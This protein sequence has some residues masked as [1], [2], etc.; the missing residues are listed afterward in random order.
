MNKA[1]KNI[2]LHSDIFQRLKRLYIIAFT[3]I[4]ASIIVSQILIQNHINSQISDSRVI[5]IAG[6]QR[7]L[8][9]KLTKEILLLNDTDNLQEREQKIQ[10][11]S[12]TFALWVKSHNGLIKGDNDLKLPAEKN[13]TI[14]EM[15]N[16]IDPN[17]NTIK[18][19]ISS[20]LNQLTAYPSTSTKT[21][22]NY[23]QAVLKHEEDF[24]FKMDNIVFKYD[25]ISNKKVKKL[26]LL[27]TILIG[28]SLLI[29]A[30]EILFLF[31]PTSIR[32]RDV[33]KDLV[34]TKQE[35]I[36]KAAELK[37]MYLSREKSLQELQELNYAID[38]AVLF[39]SISSEGNVMYISKK[40]QHFLGLKHMDIKG[41]AE[42]VI[43]IDEGHQVYLNEL[44]YNR[45]TIWHGEV[46][47]TN[48]NKE[49]KWLD[50]SI[51]PMTK[52]SSKQKTLILCN[53]ITEKKQSEV[54]LEK[55]T[56]EQFEK[57]I[58]FRKQQSINIIEA[59]E[60]E[61]KR[62]AKDIHDGIGQMLTALKF[63][64]ESINIK[65]IESSAKKVEGLKAL[66]KQIIKGVRIATFNLTP[67]ELT[68]HGIASALQNLTSQLQVLTGKTILFDNKNNFNDRLDSTIE[69]NLYRIT[70]EAVNNAIKYA[71]SNIVMV[72]MNHSE[73]LL[74]ITIDDDGI[75]FEIDTIKKDEKKG[76]GLY[77]MKERTRYING[78]LFINSS[79]D[80]GTR[81]TINTPLQ[82][83]KIENSTA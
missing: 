5:N 62:I 64:V 78:R 29:L 76:M 39:M 61:R 82:I 33:V 38:N 19:A 68:D 52:I 57:E 22:D 59:Q 56:K 53:D 24:L 15:F 69:T 65:N 25:D 45:K 16:A 10:A 1:L 42:E 13:T 70:Q 43:S 60:E 30:L 81:I 74:S 50:M 71:D 63:N 2:V 72:T 73:K 37:Q 26:K 55:I 47:I 18:T 31:K 23:I 80:D 48:H 4:V 27:E 14:I 32:I 28:A 58:E 49:K 40:F 41:M 79:K 12:N 67:P 21:I 7:M 36:N 11:I 34:S 6:R 51:I 75:G 17:F 35:A 44:F 83:E 9:Q 54:K 66:S 46:P 77:F 20:L 8:S 3:L